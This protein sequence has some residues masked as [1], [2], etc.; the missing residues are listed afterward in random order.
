M[1]TKNLKMWALIIPVVLISFMM[2]SCDKEEDTIASVTVTDSEGAVVAGAT[3]RLYAEG[4]GE[5]PVIN[6]LRFDTTGTTNGAGKVTFN[7]SEFYK[8]GQ[9]GFAVLDIE[10]YKGELEG[11]SLI[12]VEEEETSEETVVIE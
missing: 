7:F 8:Q 4:S 11:S 3:V 1:V 2:T 12:K 5:E 6:P 9:A 10:A